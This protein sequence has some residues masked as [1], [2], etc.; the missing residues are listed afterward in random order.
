[1]KRKCPSMGKNWLWEGYPEIK[2]NI[3]DERGSLFTV[4]GFGN[5]VY[6]GFRSGQTGRR[7]LVVRGYKRY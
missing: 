4:Q 7:Y 2:P 1:M 5:P 3:S 6:A